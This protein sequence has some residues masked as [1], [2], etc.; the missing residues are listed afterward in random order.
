MI[1]PVHIVATRWHVQ[2][3]LDEK[4]KKKIDPGTPF[5]AGSSDPKPNA[6][7]TELP[8]EG[9]LGQKITSI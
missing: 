3:I 1:H 9:V 8:N 7:P 4:R 5:E 2:H 6:L